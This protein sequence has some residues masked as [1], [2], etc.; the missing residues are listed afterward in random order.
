MIDFAS[1]LTQSL[2][3]ARLLREHNIFVNGL[4]L[5]FPL[6]PYMIEVLE[7]TGGH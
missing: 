1:P 2:F 4:S 6:F 3:Q 7:N 5:P